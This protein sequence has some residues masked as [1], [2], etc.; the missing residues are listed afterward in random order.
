MTC[1]ACVRR[2]EN[3]LHEV[4]GVLEA[5]VNLATARA[6]VTHAARWAG[7]PALAKV[8][9]DQ[10]YEF[11]GEVTNS[12]DDPIEKARVQELKEL[13]LKVICGAILSVIIFF[14]IHAALV[15]LFAFY[16]PPDHAD[17]HVCSDRSRGFLGGQPFF[18]RRL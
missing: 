18:Y 1:A 3:A 6:T 11:L 8:V 16:S 2:V 9:T 12:F 17:G 5:N 7:L 14:W 10:G 4:E 13:T 15:W